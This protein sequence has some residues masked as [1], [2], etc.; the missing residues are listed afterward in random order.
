VELGQYYDMRL[1]RTDTAGNVLWDQH[2]GGPEDQQCY[3]GQR[4]LDGGFIMAG[5]KYFNNTRMNMYVVKVD[6]AGNQQW[7]MAY[8]SPWIDNVGFIRQLPDSG[9]ILAGAQRLSETGLRYP[10]FY[11]LDPNGGVIWSRVYDDLVTGPFYTVPHF[12]AGQG[13][14]AAGSR[15]VGALSIGR[16]T[17]VDLAGDVLWD[18]TYQTN[19]QIDHYFYDLE[20][21]LDGGYI[22]AGTAFDSLLVSQDAWL[23][24]VDSFGCLVPGCQIFD[25][26]QEQFTDLTNALTIYPNPVTAGPMVQVGIDLPAGFNTTGA[27]SLGLVSSE[28]RLVHEQLLPTNATRAELPTTGLAPGLYF[29]HLRD[30]SRWL[31]GGKVVVTPP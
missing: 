18:R 12:I 2:Y 9:Y 4:T 19:T 7:D 6:S 16:L 27:L 15:K 24:K 30:G 13:Y 17:K 1:I 20:R 10:A 31:S 21:T 3:S 8:G 29:V 26:L 23:V 11:R 14:V 25:G 5:F 22:M 28:G